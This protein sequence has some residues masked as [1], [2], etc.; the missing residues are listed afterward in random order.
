[1]AANNQSTGADTMALHAAMLAAC[2]R[3]WA[4]YLE[5][6]E[7]SIEQLVRRNLRRRR[8]LIKLG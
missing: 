8:W 7:N 3:E 5:D 2:G 4:Q 1:M 6:L